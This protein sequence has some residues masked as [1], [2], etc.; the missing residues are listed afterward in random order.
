MLPEMQLE[1]IHTPAL[2]GNAKAALLLLHG[3]CHGA[4]MWEDNF[5]PWF[6][7]NGFDVYTMSL[8]NHGKSD[9]VANLKNIR[10]RDYVEDLSSVIKGLNKPLY[11]IGHSMGGFIIQHYLTREQDRV[12]GAA[13]LCSVPPHGLWRITVKTLWQ[14]PLAFFKGNFTRSLKP[15]FK[16]PFIANRYIFSGKTALAQTKAITE[17]PTG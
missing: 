15:I 13:L 16:D 14:F 5:A 6:A 1:V 9:S 12:T 11:L 4:W 8:R 2:H 17:R 7:Q 3:A 10:I